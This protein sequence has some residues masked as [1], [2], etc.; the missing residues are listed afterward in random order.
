[1]RRAAFLSH[2]VFQ[3]PG[4]GRHHPLS[5]RSH[6][7]VIDLACAVGAL[8]REAIVRCPLADVP[9]LLRF[10]DEGYV[11]TLAEAAAARSISPEQRLATGLGS[12]ECPLFE[13]LWDRARATV[14]GSILAAR[15]A[16]EGAIAFHPAGG[17][18]HGRPGRAAGFCYLNDPVFALLTLLD[19]GLQ[20]VLYVDL[21]AHHGDGVE[22]AFAGDP[23]VLTIS[24]HEAGRW[25]GTGALTDRREGRA[26]NL[27][28]PPRLNDTEFGRLVDGAV[29]PLAQ[30]FAP[31]AVVITCGCDS[32]AGDPLSTMALSNTAL[33]DA[34]MGLV[35]LSPRAVVLGGG[36]YNPWTAARAWAG[37][38]CRLSG[39][40][41]PERLPAEAV[42]A[43][44]ALDCDLIDT[45]DRQPAW[46]THLADEPNAGPVRPE[47][48][49]IVQAVIS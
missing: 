7:A 21:D 30:R 32:L 48:D 33:W 46:L 45:E 19:A 42:T 25:P 5:S 12:M 27:P 16:L 24:V 31:Q 11:R 38:W 14:G 15:I 23:R 41:I 18:H 22:D 1:M 8:E 36:G 29:L 35:S 39:V 4:F 43:L 44:A 26:R 20:R 47:I 9:E 2:P 13:G 40:V 17:T 3:R 37:L 10:H 6:A 28:V 49:A 34:V